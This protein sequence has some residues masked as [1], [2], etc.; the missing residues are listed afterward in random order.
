MTYQSHSLIIL[1]TVSSCRLALLGNVDFDNWLIIFPILSA[2]CYKSFWIYIHLTVNNGKRQIYSLS[3]KETLYKFDL[4]I[5]FTRNQLY[6][7]VCN[8]AHF[9]V[10][11]SSHYRDISWHSLIRHHCQLINHTLVSKALTNLPLLNIFF[12]NLGQIHLEA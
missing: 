12:I 6:K 1:W 2:N 3:L 9:K 8:Y 4:Q 5:K 11:I 10:D 7:N